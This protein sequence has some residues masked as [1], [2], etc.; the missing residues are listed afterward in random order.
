MI[1]M[2]VGAVKNIYDVCKLESR[3]QNLWVVKM[4]VRTTQVL[5]THVTSGCMKYNSCRFI[6]PVTRQRTENMCR[7]LFHEL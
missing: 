5:L 7:G 1:Q 4:M 3:T 6:L 2:K